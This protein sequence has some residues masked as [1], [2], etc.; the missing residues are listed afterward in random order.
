MLA[1]I[2]L[3]VTCAVDVVVELIGGV[4]SAKDLVFGAVERGK[5]VVTANKALVADQLVQLTAALDKRP[6]E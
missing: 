4:D 3:A 6:A 1:C 2:A 5:H